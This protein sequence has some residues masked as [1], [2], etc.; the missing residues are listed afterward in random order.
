MQRLRQILRLVLWVVFGVSALWLVVV[1]IAQGR[2]GG[3]VVP[4]LV[5]SAGAGTALVL[6]GAQEALGRM[7]RPY[8]PHSANQEQSDHLA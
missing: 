7:P 2:N 5:V 3:M 6:L 4:L 8:R 1:L